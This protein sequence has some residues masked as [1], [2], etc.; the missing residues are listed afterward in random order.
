MTELLSIDH[1]SHAAILALNNAHAVELSWLEAD[2][3]AS[4]LRQAFYARRIGDVDAFLIALDETADY[5]SPNYLWYRQR[6]ARFIY[7]D[8]VVVS[9]AA[10]GRGY[11]RLL[12]RDLS[13]QAAE[14]GHDL[15]VCEVNA[16]P[17]N[18][19]SDA[20]HAGLGFR[21]IGGATIHSGSKTVRY[22]ARRLSERD[23]E[24][25]VS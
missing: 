20:F 2:K 1:S 22:L 11:A 18:P 5:A 25:I 10:R 3:M 12:Y 24:R 7:I 8:R 14:A 6:F 17:A 16:V 15:L 9:A 21:E 23:G 19:S 4:L 13:R